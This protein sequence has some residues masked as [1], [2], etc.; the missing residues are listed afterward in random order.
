MPARR[1]VV[2]A[3]SGL[4]FISVLTSAPVDARTTTTQRRRTTTTEQRERRTTTTTRRAAATTTTRRAT[5]TTAT[6][7]PATATTATSAT[8]E[9]TSTA[10]PPSRQRYIVVLKKGNRAAAVADEH[11]Q[12]R[13][14]RVQ[15]LF[16]HAVRGYAADIAPDDID[17]IKKDNRVLYVEKAKPMRTL[18]QT[19][20][21][22]VEKVSRRGTDWSS[23]R[24]GDGTGSVSLNVYVLD[25]GVA[26]HPD[27]NGGTVFNGRGGANTDCHGHGTHM[28]GIVGAID[29]G[30]GVVGVAPGVRVNGVRV[31]DCSGRGTDLD[32][33]AG[34]EWIIG[35]GVR[36]S[37]IT[38]S[39]GGPISRAF[40]DGVRRAVSAG[41]LV[42]VAAGNDGRSAC[43]LSPAHLGGETAGVITVGATNNRDALAGFSNRGPCVDMYAPGTRITS[44]WLRSGF[45]IASGTSVSAP[46]VAGVAALF[47]AG[48]G[49]DAP[50]DVE[51]A[52][53]ANAVRISL[54]RL[55]ASSAAF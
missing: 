17:A 6:P 35:N 52:L 21:W 13:D 44:T 24:P 38:M 39:I 27:L 40:D 29:N 5:T 33:L 7:R 1:L 31:M 32:A 50:G 15:R 18:A 48:P 43:N 47:I 14:V 36:P 30:S 12:T 28:G 25:T 2:A 4:V 22:G 34:L 20:P 49:S 16:G 41:F 11:K 51:A 23:T 9:T 45:A 54:G 19:L 26:A 53:K 8:R 37:V 10:A 3:A 42:V 55:R 46:H